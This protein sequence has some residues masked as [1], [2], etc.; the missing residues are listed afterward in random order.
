MALVYL[1]IAAF[2]DFRCKRIP[3][4]V[5]FIGIVFVCA[6]VVINRTQLNYELLFAFVPGIS[7]LLLSFVTK[8]SIGYGDGVS[9]IIFGGIV[10]L[11]EC[12]FSLC[13][14][15]LLM[16]VVALGLLILRR[17]TRKTKM[18]YIPFLLMAEII[19]LVGVRV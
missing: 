18:P 10:G 12:A 7:L 14:S 4:A 11:E 13:I 5:Q 15:L 8:E 17:A 3:W 16:S 2:F 6:N 19:F 9:I 1:G